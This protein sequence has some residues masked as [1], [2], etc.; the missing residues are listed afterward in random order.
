MRKLLHVG[1]VN[2]KLTLLQVL[3]D[4]HNLMILYHCESSP[5]EIII[6]RITSKTHITDKIVNQRVSGRE[7]K[8]EVVINL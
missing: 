1:L 3:N 4:N 5:L 2:V 6:Y 7:Q 8:E